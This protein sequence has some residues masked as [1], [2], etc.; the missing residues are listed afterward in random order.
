MSERLDILLD[1]LAKNG[2]KINLRKC[3]FGV[4]ELTFAGLKLTN[5]GVIP[6]SSKV[7]ASYK[8]QSSD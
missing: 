4:E 5:K 3:I 1:T 6:D 2:L 7:E 8:C